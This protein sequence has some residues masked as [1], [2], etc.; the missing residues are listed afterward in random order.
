M[1]ILLDI[2]PGIHC[3]DIL[4]TSIITLALGKVTHNRLVAGITGTVVS[5]AAGDV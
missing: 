4:F 2:H 5:A 3:F 1:I